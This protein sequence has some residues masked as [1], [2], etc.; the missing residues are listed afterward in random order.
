MRF[1]IILLVVPLT[2]GTAIAQNDKPSASSRDSNVSPEAERVYTEKDRDVTPPKAKYSEAPEYPRNAR[3]SGKE[4]TVVL[5]VVVG[6]DGRPRDPRIARSVSPEL[7][8]AAIDT[9]RKW[10]FSPAIKDRT[11]VPY[12]IT[13]QMLFKL[14]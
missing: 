1:W 2:L 12:L 6:N 14:Y 3:G 11:P 7:D 8:Q 9:L 5:S 4:G 13:V 10:K